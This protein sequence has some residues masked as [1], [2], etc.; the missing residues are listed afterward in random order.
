LL[1]C[2]VWRLSDTDRPGVRRGRRGSLYLG[3]AAPSRNGLRTV[4]NLTAAA[5]LR[6]KL[7]ATTTY[8]KGIFVSVSSCFS[9]PWS[10]HGF[11]VF[12][13]CGFIFADAAADSNS[14]QHLSLVAL[15][16][17][18]VLGGVP[19]SNGLQLPAFPMINGVL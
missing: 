7:T 13:C 1:W 6:T 9:F 8:H 3:D 14:Y 18:A 5:R 19:T 10:Q 16:N 17:V 4:I 2:R 11:P 15:A 12:W